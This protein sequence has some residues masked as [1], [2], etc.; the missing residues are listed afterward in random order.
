MERFGSVQHA[1]EAHYRVYYFDL[2]FH[3]LTQWDLPKVLPEDLAYLVDWAQKDAGTDTIELLGYSLGAKIC[4]NLYLRHPERIGRLW[5]LAPD[6]MQTRYLHWVEKLP[7]FMF[8]RVARMGKEPDKLQQWAK[9]LRDKGIIPPMA[10]QFVQWNLS[11]PERRRR[12]VAMWHTLRD[13]AVPA[14]QLRRTIEREDTPVEL[15]L[16]KNDPYIPHD[17]WLKWATPIAQVNLKSREVGHRLLDRATGE[18]IRKRAR[19]E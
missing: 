15:L 16:G 9:G 1:L 6:G 13:F 8:D 4:I 19:G 5:L 14:K 10:Y 18:W 11:T 2:P 12:A 17:V 7:G 3:G